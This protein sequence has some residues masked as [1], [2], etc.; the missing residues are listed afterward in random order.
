MFGNARKYGIWMGNFY[1]KSSSLRNRIDFKKLV[2]DLLQAGSTLVESK[3]IRRKR[4][5]QNSQET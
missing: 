2:S 3:D 1:F 5:Y 4:G